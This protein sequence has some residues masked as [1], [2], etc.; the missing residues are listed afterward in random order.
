MKNSGLI[1]VLAGLSAL[2]VSAKLVDG[3]FENSGS[4]I[5][6]PIGSG[7]TLTQDGALYNQTEAGGVSSLNKGWYSGNANEI[8]QQGSSN[9]FAL[10][11]PSGG[12]TSSSK[13]Y[14]G[15][16]WTDASL[17]GKNKISFEIT[18]AAYLSGSDQ[19]VII[20]VYTIPER[21]TNNQKLKLSSDV[22][23][24]TLLGSQVV[25][26]SNGIGSYES[27][28]I[29]FT[30]PSSIYAIRN[31]VYSPKGSCEGNLGLDNISI[32]ISHEAETLGLISALSEM[33]SPPSHPTMI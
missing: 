15:Q 10:I 5:S 28:S 3:G 12:W 18:D 7:A 20:E 11:S 8:S 14:I 17:A 21:T 29:D 23:S 33:P 32:S 31:Q 25:D 9:K 6:T 22:S 16:M 26:I 30:A 27:R 2:S 4:L 24:F 1:I 19:I 13:F